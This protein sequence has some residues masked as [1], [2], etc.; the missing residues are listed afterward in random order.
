M[1]RVRLTNRVSYEGKV[2]K[3]ENQCKNICKCWS[4]AKADDVEK[5]GNCD[6]CNHQEQ[7]MPECSNYEPIT[8]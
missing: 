1:Q 2:V 7:K 4:C 5:C 8:E 3:E 6:K